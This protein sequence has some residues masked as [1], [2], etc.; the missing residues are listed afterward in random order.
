MT[1]TQ[2]SS[3][4]HGGRIA[5]KRALVC[6]PSGEQRGDFQDLGNTR[7]QA[8]PFYG[9][10]PPLVEQSFCSGAF[11]AWSRVAVD[12]RRTMPPQLAT[13]VRM[14]VCVCVCVRVCVHV[15]VCVCVCVW[16]CVCAC[17]CVCMC[18]RPCP[19]ALEYARQGGG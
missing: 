14:C 10:A 2:L 8:G 17:V 6:A 18:A 15:S 13:R 7:T 3:R 9:A 5:A 16:L 1:D 12:V 19:C 11:S 4:Q